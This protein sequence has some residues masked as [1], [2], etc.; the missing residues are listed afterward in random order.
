MNIYYVVFSTIY[1][2]KSAS[3]QPRT[4]LSKLQ[5]RRPGKKHNWKVS[6]LRKA[7]IVRQGTLTALLAFSNFYNCCQE[8]PCDPNAS[9]GSTSHARNANCEF[10]Q[11]A[12]WW[13]ELRI[14]Y[15]SDT[16]FLLLCVII[17]CIL[18]YTSIL[19]SCCMLQSIPNAYRR[20]AT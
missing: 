1:L 6:R 19:R 15:R 2:Q 8:R 20:V 4:S 10:S 12:T 17:R 9:R 13:L 16:E 14:A 18:H 7:D 3:I 11:R 5:I